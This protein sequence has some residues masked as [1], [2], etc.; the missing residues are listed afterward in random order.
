MK[1]ERTGWTGSN[2]ANKEDY[3]TE[4][5]GLMDGRQAG[6]ASRAV[7]GKDSLA[8]SLTQPNVHIL[9]ISLDLK[10]S[11]VLDCLPFSTGTV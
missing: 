10:L 1:K 6:Y 8:E 7:P 3:F 5:N 4:V 11:I 2:N 9:S